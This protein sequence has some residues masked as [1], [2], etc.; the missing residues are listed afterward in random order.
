MKKMFGLMMASFIFPAVCLWSNLMLV[1]PQGEVDVVL[2][3][4][5]VDAT[6]SP[7]PSLPPWVDLTP[8]YTIRGISTTQDLIA[9]IETGA[10]SWNVRSPQSVYHESY[11]TTETSQEIYALFE[12]HFGLEENWT[13]TA[14]GSFCYEGGSALM[15]LYIESKTTGVQ[16]SVYIN[17]PSPYYTC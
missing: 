7:T 9:M 10:L 14:R 5:Q 17:V 16:V 8:T 13:R 3:S 2:D 4:M 12:E 15:H 1:S 11:T 6:Y